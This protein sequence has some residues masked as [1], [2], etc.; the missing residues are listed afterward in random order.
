MDDPG[1]FSFIFTFLAQVTD[2]AMP[3]GDLN[4]VTLV[5]QLVCVVIGLI[6]SAFFSGSEVAFFS[7]SNQ[8]DML[9]EHDVEGSGDQL[10]A[11]MLERPQRLL[12][13]ILIGNTFANIITSILAAV[14]TGNI[15]AH[16]GFSE[17]VVFAL[18]IVALTFTILILSEIT[19]K[20]IAINSPLNAARKLGRFVYVFYV[21]LKPVSKLIANS[22]IRIEE[23]IPRPDS[24]MTTQDIMAMAEVS[25]QEGSIK[26]DEREIIENVIEFGTTSV[27]EIMTS[28]VNIVAV[29]TENTLEEV[30]ALIREKGLSR[31]PLYEND[32]DTILGIILSLIHI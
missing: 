20:V 22:T 25:E 31:M 23:S 27:R 11:R 5:I 1:S 8:Q 28:R 12:A 19:P 30:L 18:E 14:V 6:F 3:A 9:V 15:I 10:I 29:S 4:I 21:L 24:R 26:S 16:F 7:L 32:L 17:V 13:T 2:L